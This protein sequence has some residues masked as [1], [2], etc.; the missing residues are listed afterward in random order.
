[1]VVFQVLLLVIVLPLVVL[2]LL[3]ISIETIR[4]P[5]G[6]FMRNQS[7]KSVES[8]LLF[9]KKIIHTTRDKRRKNLQKTPVAQLG[10]NWGALARIGV[11][12]TQPFNCILVSNGLK[13]ESKLSKTGAAP[14]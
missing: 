14:S 3:G 5:G 10:R 1:M 4:T 2:R 6:E 13:R 12:T 11:T 7:E 9:G 8:S